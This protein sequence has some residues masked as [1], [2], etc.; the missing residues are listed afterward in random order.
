VDD[1]VA[2]L[3][4]ALDR[5]ELDA[6]AGLF[7]EA[8]RS[9]QPTH[10]GR[11][12]VGR[13]QVRASWEAMFAG[14]PDVRVVALRSAQ[15]QDTTRTQWRWSGTR[16]D[17][18]PFDGRGVTIFETTGGHIVAGHLF[19]EEV[20]SDSPDIEEAVEHLSGTRPRSTRT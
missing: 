18:Q 2:R 1:V 11:A 3:A 16:S 8:H 14:V 7:D 9:E 6:A 17:G 13:A 5:H 12:F 4:L 15:E 20:E 10:P 19:M